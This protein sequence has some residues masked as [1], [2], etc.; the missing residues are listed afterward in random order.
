MVGD[1]VY[2]A[3]MDEYLRKKSKYNNQLENWDENNAKGYYLVL[4]YFPKELEAELQNQDYWKTAEEARSVIV[5]LL[6]IWYLS[7]NK[8]D[9]KSSIM[10]TVEA[11]AD[12]YLGTQ[13]PYQITDE[14]YKTF[15]AQVD[16]INVNGGSAGFHSG[17]YNKHMLVLWDRDL[18][19]ADSLKA[20]IPAEKTALEN[21]LRAAARST[22]R[23]FSSSG[24]TRKG[25][26]P[27]RRS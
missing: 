20:M 21:C 5:I 12:L 23:A 2:Q 16:T 10:A 15:T 17:V 1:I 11:D 27:A 6:L 22:S 24:R 7:L 3:T 9:R 19:T 26:S 8:M 18:V 4:Q 25:S 14:F 13:R